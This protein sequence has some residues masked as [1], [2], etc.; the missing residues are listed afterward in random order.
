MH[1][2]YPVILDVLKAG[3]IKS[4]PVVSFFHHGCKNTLRTKL[5]PLGSG[6]GATG[7]PWAQSRECPRLRQ[8]V[9]GVGCGQGPGPRQGVHIFHLKPNAMGKARCQGQGPGLRNNGL[10]DRARARAQKV[11]AKEGARAKGPG[12]RARGQGKTKGPGPGPGPRGK[13]K[14]T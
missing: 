7:M 12:A 4:F 10:R 1:W 5:L 13:H 11:R 2:P 3:S 9:S 6:P 8:R 14:N